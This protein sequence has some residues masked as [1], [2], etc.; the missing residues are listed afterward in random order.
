MRELYKLT[1][2][3]IPF[4]WSTECQATFDKSKRLLLSNNLLIHYD[5]NKPIVIHCDASPY[6]LGAILSH[7]IDGRD[8]P[9]LFTSCTL[10]KAQQNYAQLYKEALAIVFAVKKF[11][12][13]IF[14]KRFVIFSDHQPLRDI[15]NETKSMPIATGQLQRWAVFLAMYDYR[16]EYKRGSKLGNA[17]ALS[18]LPLATENDIEQKN[19]HE[20]AEKLPLNIV[21]IAKQTQDDGILS[22]VYQQLLNGWKH[23]TNEEVKPYFKKKAMLSIDNECIFYGN[24]IVVPTS[25]KNEVLHLLHDTHIGVCRMKASV[26]QYVWWITIDKDIEA[27]ARN[28]N[29]CQQMQASPSKT[30]LAKWKETN[31]FFERIHL[32]FFHFHEKTFLLV[33]D[34]Y[35]RWF[36]VK[37]M[38][39]TTCEKL[40]G[41]LRTIF[42]YFGLPR[43]V[44][45]DNGPPFNAREFIRFCNNNNIECLKSPPYHPQSNGWAECG[46]RTVKNS[47]R[48]M[49]LES[50]NN[51]TVPLLLS[52]FLIKYRNTP[53]TTTGMCPNERI[54]TYRPTI[55]M[56]ALKCKPKSLLANTDEEKADK[57]TMVAG[58][59]QSTNMNSKTSK[60]YSPNEM[61]LYRNEFKKEA[62]WMKAKII[63]VLSK[64]RYTIEL[65][66]RGSRREC[67]GDQLRPYHIKELPTLPTTCEEKPAREIGTATRPSRRIT[68]NRRRPFREATHPV[69]RS[70]R[71]KGKVRP[72][73]NESRARIIQNRK[74]A[75]QK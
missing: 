56:D 15:F 38:K 24:R 33:V 54:F 34:A 70:D 40:I 37:H 66:T 16:I 32:D 39:S 45:S 53:V 3:D 74:R 75:T 10:T 11:H 2:K 8:K 68:H 50:G 13:Y 60:T 65:V 9:V 23:A 20:F 36:D 7:V 57:L 4:V 72:N 14:G 69:R 67:H 71:N 21:K 29:E 42:A 30:P 44:V 52:R 17:D 5:P 61:V 62:K 46:V 6:G 51:A 49:L 28:C 63:R 31:F 55:L 41:E 58:T 73:Y 22:E 47:L 25:L 12:K 19:V 26:R 27:Y 35:A 1:Q 59:K 64:S 18:R 48:K 43:M